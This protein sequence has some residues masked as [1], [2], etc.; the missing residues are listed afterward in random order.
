MCVIIH[1]I[2]S[3]CVST[4]CAFF[5]WMQFSHA[6]F[7]TGGPTA[8]PPRITS[9]FAK[10]TNPQFNVL[11]WLEEVPIGSTVVTSIHEKVESEGDAP[12]VTFCH[13]T[14]K[15]TPWSWSLDV[16]ESLSHVRGVW[17]DMPPQTKIENDRGPVLN[18]T[19]KIMESRCRGGE[20][21]QGVQESH[22]PSAPPVEVIG[23]SEWNAAVEAGHQKQR[24]ESGGQGVQEPGGPGFAWQATH[25]PSAPPVEESGG[26]GVQEPPV[27]EVPI[28][29]DDGFN[30]KPVAE[31]ASCHFYIPRAVME[32][33]APNL[34]HDRMKD[35]KMPEGLAMAPLVNYHPIAIGWDWKVMEYHDSAL[36]YDEAGNNL[37]N[38]IPKDTTKITN[39]T[40][41]T[42]IGKTNQTNL[43]TSHRHRLQDSRTPR[44]P[45]FL[46][47]TVI[48]TT[49]NW[50]DDYD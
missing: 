49:S 16:K 12:T 29:P 22:M 45:N 44:L 28:T 20:G 43:T 17:I 30:S 26:Q 7:S 38:L 36:V 19:C 50:Y 23:G 21:G 42:D 4:D 14:A 47:F 10:A 40:N 27:Q 32:R 18:I 46:K 1:V 9:G 2:V 3:T 33:T 39:T 31:N 41:T 25:M 11:L 5:K 48:A 6:S 15:I 37:D 8:V 35:S 13:G 34:W 24:E